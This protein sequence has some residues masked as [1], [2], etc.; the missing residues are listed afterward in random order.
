MRRDFQSVARGVKKSSCLLLSFQFGL[1]STECTL[2]SQVL[3][4]VNIFWFQIKEFLIYFIGRLE[5]LG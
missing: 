5:S 1:H 2:N 4:H 3:N